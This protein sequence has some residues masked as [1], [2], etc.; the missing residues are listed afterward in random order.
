MGEVSEEGR[1]E[2]AL[3]P[4]NQASLKGFPGCLHINEFPIFSIRVEVPTPAFLPNLKH[5]P[6]STHQ[7]T[8]GSH[9]DISRPPICPG[10]AWLRP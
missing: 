4:G 3:L 10:A 9:Q 1:R 6:H 8:C 5:P 7:V 2:E